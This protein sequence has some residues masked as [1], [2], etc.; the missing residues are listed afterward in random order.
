MKMEFPDE[1]S[2]L[3]FFESEPKDSSPSD[4]YWCYEATDSLGTK[5]KL[6]FNIH[7]GSV[8]TEIFIEE[9]SI[10]NIVQEGATCLYL[11]DYYSEKILQGEFTFSNAHTTLVVQIRPKIRV[12]WSTLVDE[13]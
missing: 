2:L 11:S 7:E 9:Q 3:E 4:G 5:L 12:Q 6:S 8:Q 10:A 1:V 13:K